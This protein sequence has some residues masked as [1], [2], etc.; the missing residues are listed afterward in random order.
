MPDL[1]QQDLLAGLKTRL[2]ALGLS[3]HEDAKQGLVGEA[4]P[5]RSKWWLGAR[6]VT[7]RMSCRPSEA[8]RTVQ[9]REAVTESSWGLPPPTVTVEK[10]K[11]SGWKLSGERSDVS[12]GGGGTIDYAKVRDAV[13]QAVAAAGW[14]FHLQGGRL[15]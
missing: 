5:I 6:T 2:G 12:P 15:P 13:E 10:T 9:F 1:S 7:Y 8:D 4:Q 14:T 11:V 3:V